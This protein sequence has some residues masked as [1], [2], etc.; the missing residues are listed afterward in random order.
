LAEAGFVV[1][2]PMHPGDNFRNSSLVGRPEWLADRSRHVSQMIDF[3]FA[4]WEGRARLV[5]DRVG[6]FGFSAGA[7]T[8]LISIGGVPDLPESPRTTRR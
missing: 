1:V 2:A 7:T 8:A 4:T 3:M 5:R 6:I